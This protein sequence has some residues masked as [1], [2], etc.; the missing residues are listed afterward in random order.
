MANEEL[1]SLYAMQQQQQQEQDV[2]EQIAADF[3]ARPLATRR[4]L[5]GKQAPPPAYFAA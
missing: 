4:R 5:R 3:R 1:L 2:V